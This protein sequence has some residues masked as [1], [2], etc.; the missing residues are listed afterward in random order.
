MARTAISLRR[1]ADSFLA[2]AFP[3]FSPP[4]R[5]KATAAAFFFGFAMHDSL[6]KP[7]AVESAI[8]SATGYV[9]AAWE[10]NSAFPPLPGG[11]LAVPF[12]GDAQFHR[13]DERIETGQFQAVGGQQGLDFTVFANDDERAQD[14][15]ELFFS[16]ADRSGV[17]DDGW[18]IDG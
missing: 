11:G 1:L 16:D 14:R 3:P 5:P 4:S 17:R 7:E 6:H 8:R 2:R 9:R 12:G 13:R 18:W 10:R 15:Q